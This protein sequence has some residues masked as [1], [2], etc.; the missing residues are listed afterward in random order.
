METLQWRHNGRDCVSNHQS[1]DCLLNRLFR[2]R[3]E[4]TSKLRVT[5]L[6]VGNSPVAGEFSHKSTVRR[7]M[8]P[9]DDVIMRNV[10][11]QEYPLMRCRLDIKVLDQCVISVN[12]W[13]CLISPVPDQKQTD[14]SYPNPVKCN[15]LYLVFINMSEFTNFIKTNF[16]EISNL[17]MFTF[18]S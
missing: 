13:L 17:S 12:P 6:C 11:R 7:K 15:F 18:L 14:A 10:S 8:F 16:I 4:K 5:G 1:Y 2:R 3:S 9:F